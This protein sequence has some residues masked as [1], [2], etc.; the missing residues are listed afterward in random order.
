MVER[1]KDDFR[2][3]IIPIVLD[4]GRRGAGW[5]REGEIGPSRR[6]LFGCIFYAK[7]QMMFSK[8][9]SIIIGNLRC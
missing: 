7:C 1:E 4:L 5:F 3:W 6:W 2:V 9:V 8:M